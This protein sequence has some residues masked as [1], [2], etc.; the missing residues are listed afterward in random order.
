MK[1]FAALLNKNV[2]INMRKYRKFRDHCHYTGKYRGTSHSIY[3]L[4]YNL[5]KVIPIVFRNVSNYDYRFIIKELVQEFKGE[6]TCLGENT[7]KCIAFA[8]P[9]EK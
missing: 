8:L 4:K 6:L 2:K 9:I 5:P 1:Q 7:E 3:N